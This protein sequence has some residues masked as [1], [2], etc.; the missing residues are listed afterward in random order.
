M[1]FATAPSPVCSSSCS[2]CEFDVE[3]TRQSQ[4]SYAKEI[5][6]RG[7]KLEDRIVQVLKQCM[8]ERLTTLK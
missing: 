7:W 4:T 8:L 3:E 6:I 2:Q 1:V 5:Y